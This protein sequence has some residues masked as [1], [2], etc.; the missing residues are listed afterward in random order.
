MVGQA[1]TQQATI[2]TASRSADPA[3]TEK[4]T[5]AAVQPQAPK[6][7]TVNLTIG[8]L[9]AG[10]SITVIFDA[11]IA[12]PVPPD[13]TQ[14]SNQGT[15][16]GSNFANV[17][18]NDPDAAGANNPTVTPLNVLDAKRCGMSLNTPYSFN[19]GAP[20][21]V[22]FTQFGDLSC[23]QVART[24]AIRLTPQ[25]PSRRAATGRSRPRT[26]SAPQPPAIKRRWSC[27]KA[28]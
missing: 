13:A 6:A 23:L 2:G 26:L 9:P 12:N 15:V 7:G 1:S 21:V 19:T 3:P 20:V 8:T 5:G 10:K 11:V 25:P 14:V 24:T 16:S 22:T 17:L 27:R 18:T 28:T 4:P